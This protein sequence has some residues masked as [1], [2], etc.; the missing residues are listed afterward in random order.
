MLVKWVAVVMC[1]G[2]CSVYGVDILKVMN[3]V[4]LLHQIKLGYFKNRVAS[5]KHNTADLA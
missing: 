3:Q 5:L 2:M 1:D 4:C